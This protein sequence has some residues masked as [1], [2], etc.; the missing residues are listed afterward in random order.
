MNVLV[1]RAV[2]T[3]AAI[4]LSAGVSSCVRPAP[5]ND[6]LPDLPSVRS[7]LTDPMVS[8]LAAEP[9]PRLFI[10]RMTWPLSASLDPL[11]ELIETDAL[12]DALAA[13]W[14]ANG[15]RLGT[16]DASRLPELGHV[17]DRADRITTTMLVGTRHFAPQP[18]SPP[19]RRPV[20]I[21]LVER[22]EDPKRISVARGRMQW[23]IRAQGG[24]DGQ[25]HLELVPHHHVKK[26]SLMPRSPLQTQQDGRTFD[27]LRLTTVMRPDRL[28]VMGLY[29]PPSAQP[30]LESE[31][32]ETSLANEGQAETDKQLQDCEDSDRRA[33]DSR[34]LEEKIGVRVSNLV[35]GS[36]N[37]SEEDGAEEALA[38]ATEPT[39][40]AAS[41]EIPAHLGRLLFTASRLNYPLQTV[42]VIGIESKGAE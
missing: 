33:S 26:F 3:A 27:D 1:R 13:L 29:L 18:T 37:G 24:D 30:E 40:P 21:D 35:S 31:A 39:G 16:I 19:L 38:S 8:L 12:P 10:H 7:R 14:Q 4:A 28:L 41:V 20:Q 17:F 9:P 42:V 11:W 36:E 6:N 2:T 23:L 25:V 34:S 32:Q 22:F 5:P 15:M